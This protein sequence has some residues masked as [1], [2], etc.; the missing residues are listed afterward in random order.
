LASG[1]RGQLRRRRRSALAPA[2]RTEALSALQH[3]IEHRLADFGTYEDAMLAGDR[4]MAH[5]VLSPALNLG[6]LHPLECVRAAES[7]YRAGKPR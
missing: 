7:A 2:T 1:R 6:L 3:F 4:T 5:S